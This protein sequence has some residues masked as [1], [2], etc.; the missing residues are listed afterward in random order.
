MR[1]REKKKKS[2]EMI[3]KVSLELAK[4]KA[5]LPS[6]QHLFLSRYPDFTFN[7]FSWRK[8]KKKTKRKKMIKNWTGGGKS[9][10]REK[11]II[12]FCYFV[13]TFEFC[14]LATKN[15]TVVFLHDC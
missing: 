9:L 8:S 1:Y 7:F 4:T 5:A 3:T 11:V 10:L 12:E 6:V 14:L 13:N 15:K 2:G